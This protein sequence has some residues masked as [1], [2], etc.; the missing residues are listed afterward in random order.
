MIAGGTQAVVITA[1][2]SRGTPL[3]NEVVKVLFKDQN[4]TKTQLY[5]GY[6]DSSGSVEPIIKAPDGLQT[7]SKGTLIVEAAGETMT[8]EVTI[9]GTESVQGAGGKLFIST[10][11]PLYQPEQTVHIRTLGFEGQNPTA[12]KRPVTVEV[13]DPKGDL[14]YKKDIQP[15]DY[16]V[17]AVDFPL[18]DQL[19]VGNYQISGTLG[20]IAKANQTILVKRYVLPKFKID[21]NGT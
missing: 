4:G 11:K 18:S 6:T 1:T 21:V 13:Q 3:I 10:D 17:A 20:G 14:I 8:K 15:N 12:S 2:N 16:G 5:E 7:G 19:P 9:T